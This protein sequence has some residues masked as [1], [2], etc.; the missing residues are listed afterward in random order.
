VRREVPAG[1][2]RKEENLD[3]PAEAAA[4]DIVRLFG[5]G[6]EVEEVVEGQDEREDVRVRR[7]YAKLMLIFGRSAER[8][9]TRR[10]LSLQTAVSAQLNTNCFSFHCLGCNLNKTNN[11]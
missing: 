5:K 9:A 3:A 6:K 10:A 1:W 7:R 11:L 2:L 4:P 8:T